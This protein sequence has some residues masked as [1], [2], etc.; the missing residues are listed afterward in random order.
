M[1]ITVGQATREESSLG[2]KRAVAVV[3]SRI[4]TGGRDSSRTVAVEMEIYTGETG[5]D[6]TG[7]QAETMDSG[8]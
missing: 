2:S 3:R 1:Y 7:G 6:R 4:R 5:N 8:E